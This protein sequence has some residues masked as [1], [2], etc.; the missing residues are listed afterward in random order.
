MDRVMRGGLRPRTLRASSA[1]DQHFFRPLVTLRLAGL[2]QGTQGCGF[3]A[4]HGLDRIM[5]FAVVIYSFY[6]VIYGVQPA[7]EECACVCACVHVCVY[8]YMHKTLHTGWTQRHKPITLALR[9]L[10]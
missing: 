2:L 4:M 10:E 8:I 6:Y 1:S 9:K 5:V 3:Q 7:I